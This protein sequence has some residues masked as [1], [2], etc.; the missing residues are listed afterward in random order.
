MIRLDIPNMDETL[1]ALTASLRHMPKECEIAAVRAINRTL[2]A[3][4]AEAIRIAKRSYVHV[5]G[6]LFDQLYLKKARRGMTEACLYIS[7]RRGISLYHF[8]PE[9]KFPGNRPPAGVSAQVRQGGTRKVYQQP[10]YSKPFIMKKLRGT[11]FGGYGVFMREKGVN[12]YHRK[13]RKGAEGL[14]WKGVKMLFGASPIQSLLKKENQRQ[15]VD[16]ASEVFPRRL[17]HEID[18]QIAKL[19]SQGKMR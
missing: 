11:E 7:G 9:P 4:R 18:F 19:A 5:P 6:R 10:G 12:N 2:N 1:R 13:G 15:I 3:M 14:V 16:K 8:R 17:Q